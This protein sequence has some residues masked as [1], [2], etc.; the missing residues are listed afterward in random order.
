MRITRPW[1]RSSRGVACL[2][3]AAGLLLTSCGARLSPRQLA[4]ALG[5]NGGTGLNAG[6]QGSSGAGGV[7]GGTGTTSAAGGPL[8]GGTTGTT[9]ASGTSGAGGGAGG[10]GLT[11]PPGGNGGATDVGV[12]PNSITVGNISTLTGPVPGLFAGAVNGTD[13]FLAYQNSQGGVFGRQ[14]K[15][16]A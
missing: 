13:A 9:G 14:L 10:L 2:V 4:E 5:A 16:A 12:T 1:G 8:A 6:G 3:A 7:G 15:L 11:L